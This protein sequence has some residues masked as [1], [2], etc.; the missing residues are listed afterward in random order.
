MSQEEDK[1]TANDASKF[2]RNSSNNDDNVH[3]EHSYVFKV[4]VD[5][6]NTDKV[7]GILVDYA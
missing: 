3:D 2:V 5:I 1:E 6:N 7:N 4:G